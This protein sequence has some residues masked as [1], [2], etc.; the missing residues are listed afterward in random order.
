MWSA[1][2]VAIAATSPIEWDYEP[3]PL[4]ITISPD[5]VMSVWIDHHEAFRFCP[6]FYLPCDMVIDGGNNGP[7]T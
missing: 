4:L 7:N 6:P 3:E 1:L 5:D 2:L